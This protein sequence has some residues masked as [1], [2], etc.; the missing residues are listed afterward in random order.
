MRQNLLVPLA[1]ALLVVACGPPSG[2][3]VARVASPDGR[4][5]AVLLEMNG[6]ATTSFGYEVHVLEKGK[7][8]GDRVA[9]LYGAV[10]NAHAYGANLKWASDTELTV[11]FLEAREQTLEKQTVRIVGR[12]VAIVLKPGVLDPDAP[13]GGMFYNLQMKKRGSE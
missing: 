13:A 3:E 9:Q 6:G 4:V 8:P 10:R 11:E 7:A 1:L 12:D 5:E 2:D